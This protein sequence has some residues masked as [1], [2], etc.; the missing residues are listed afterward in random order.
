MGGVCQP[1][2]LTT[3][4]QGFATGYGIA[5]DATNVY[6]TIAASSNAGTVNKIPLSGGVATTLVGGLG[7]AYALAINATT[8]FFTTAGSPGNIGSCAIAGCGGVP[9]YLSTTETFPESIAVDPVKGIVYWGNYAKPGSTV[10]YCPIGGC[11]GTPTTFASGFN[12]TSSITVDANHVYWTNLADNTVDNSG[13]VGMAGSGTV[14]ALASGVGSPAGISVDK[15]NV[16]FVTNGSG[17]AVVSVPILFG[18]TTTIFSS[19]GSNFAYTVSDGQYVYWTTSGI[20]NGS[21]SK[22]LLPTCAGGP[23]V[24]ASPLAFP[25]AITADSVAVYWVQNSSLMKVA[26]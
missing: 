26:K 5:V 16:Y 17:G 1:I 8:V 24:L 11:G 7:S 2:T 6:W 18:P 25:E 23:T 4:S 12:N 13:L 22:C 14:S 3:W 9:T 20:A 19:A 21:V 15:N 10:R